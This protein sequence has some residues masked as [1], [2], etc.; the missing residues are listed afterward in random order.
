MQE[1]SHPLKGAKPTAKRKPAAPAAAAAA[2]AG[3][4]EGG[5]AWADA[6]VSAAVHV[7]A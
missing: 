5:V 1:R 4:A 7:A 6:K 3:A 2:E